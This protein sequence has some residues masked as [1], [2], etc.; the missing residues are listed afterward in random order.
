MRK[1]ITLFAFTAGMAL[2]LQPFIT[3]TNII[4][5]PTSA[6]GAPGDFGTC[7]LAGCHTG[8][9]VISTG[10]FIILQS[11]GANNLNSAGYIPDTTYNLSVNVANINKP[12]YGFSITVLDANDNPAGI[13]MLTTTPSSTTAINTQNGRTYVSHKNANS[14]AAWAFKWKAP[15]S[16]I[17]PV[18]FYIAANGANND[19]QAPFNTALNSGDQIYT[20]SYSV[21]ATQ[22]LSREGG[23]TGIQAL[24][25]DD[26]GISIFP[27]P[28]SN[29]VSFSYGLTDNKNVAASLFN[30]NGQMIQE[31][32]N[33][34]QN[35]GHY[36]QTFNINTDIALGLYIIQVKMDD[37]VF[38]KKVMVQ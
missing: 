30:L 4:Q 34:A 20:T 12:R 14:T 17:G 7:A 23:G 3:L 37:A 13:L 9:S 38:F 21:S 10:N 35:A 6:T 25:A 11:L 19:G 28:I 24:N 18:K 15:S 36:N 33:E 32:F 16:N 27:N 5:P 31:F 29:K 1:L 26:N 2:M 22:G 8:S